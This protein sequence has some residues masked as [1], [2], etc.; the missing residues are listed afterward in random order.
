MAEKTIKPPAASVKEYN[1]AWMT[2]FP[3]YRHQDEADT[4]KAG[5]SV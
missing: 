2:D 5:V 1:N 3:W 4:A